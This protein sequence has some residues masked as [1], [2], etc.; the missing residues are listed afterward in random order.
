MWIKIAIVLVF[1]ALVASLLTGFV[2]L[3]KDE[4]QTR[5]LW[6]S[7]AVRLALASLLIG[8]LIY[9]VYTGELGSRA[10]WDIK[11]AAPVSSPAQ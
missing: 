10:P 8:L 3:L 5:R 11:R 2:F 9:G 7:L 6:N 4:S 1:I